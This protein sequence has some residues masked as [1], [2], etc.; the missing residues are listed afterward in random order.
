MTSLP[1]GQLL[2]DRRYRAGG[3]LHA[4]V[5]RLSQ[6]G[7]P[8]PQL[9]RLLQQRSVAVTVEPLRQGPFQ[10]R[11]I[12]G[13]EIGR[14]CRAAFGRVDEIQPDGVAQQGE[15]DGHVGSMPRQ[16][17]RYCDRRAWPDTA[18]CPLRQGRC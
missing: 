14:R 5:K 10:H 9:Q 11:G 17:R 12:V 1:L 6:C 3:R 8:L 4:L 18:R 2:V 13:Q 7:Q 15:V 16:P